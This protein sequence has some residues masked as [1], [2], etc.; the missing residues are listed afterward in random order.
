MR[1][2]AAFESGNVADV[3]IVRPDHVRLRARAD[4]SPRPLWFYFC[5][6]EAAAPAVRVD[7]VN[8]DE[9]FGSRLEWREARPVFSGDGVHWQRVARANYVEETL[10]RGYFTFQVPVVGRRTYAAYG[11]PYTTTDLHRFLLSLPPALPEAELQVETWGRTA[12]G[13]GIPGV[14]LG[15]TD[16]AVRRVFVI[17]RQHAGETPASFVVEGL[18]AALAG[19]DEEARAARAAVEFQVVPM[20]DLDGVFHGRYGKDAPPVDFNRDWTDTPTRPEIAAVAA[21]VAAWRGAPLDRR[22]PSVPAQTTGRPPPRA[23]GRPPAAPV[24][25]DLF[26]DLHGSAPGDLACYL[27]GPPLEAEPAHREAVERLMA[28]LVAEAP[29]TLGLRAADLRPEAPPPHSAREDVAAR[30][31]IPSVCLE[32][33]YHQC[34]SGEWMTPALYRALGAALARALWQRTRGCASALRHRGAR[35]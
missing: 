5:V 9:C 15:P 28:A 18:I 3:Q 32:I 7:L 21:R 11:Y 34:Q 8:A 24:E 35:R 6:E 19:D 10:R 23:D 27:F 29:P 2:H 33:S 22:P 4:E 20:V 30:H 14:R 17:A 16:G 31:G 13:R 12:E 25:C 26:L 1:V